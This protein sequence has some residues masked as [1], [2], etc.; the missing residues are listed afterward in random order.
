MRCNRSDRFR[1]SFI[2]GTQTKELPP[3]ASYFA[4]HWEYPS[5]SIIPLF[6]ASYPIDTP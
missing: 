6:E 3:G 2:C 1:A 5:G 4:H